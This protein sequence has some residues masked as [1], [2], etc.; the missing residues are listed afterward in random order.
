MNLNFN[1]IP[2][3]E[4]PLPPKPT[5]YP[6]CGPVT[7]VFRKNVTSYKGIPF[8]KPPV[9]P[10][11]FRPPEPAPAWISPRECFE[12]SDKCLQFGGILA[13]LPPMYSAV[14]KSEDCL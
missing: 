10:L 9:G 6:P 8:A 2:N 11:R 14:G 4:A 1:M 13:D 12:F 3:A 7:G 5:I